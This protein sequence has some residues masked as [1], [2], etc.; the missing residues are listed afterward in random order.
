MNKLSKQILNYF[1]AFTETRFNFRRLISY[2]WTN[3]ELTMS[4]DIYD[5]FYK[6][7]FNG[8]KMGALQ[9]FT[10]KKGEYSVFISKNDFLSRIIEV[11]EKDYNEKYLSSC[12]KTEAEEIARV[13]N[14]FIASSQGLRIAL[15]GDISEEALEQRQDACIK[16]AIRKYNLSLRAKIEVILL[17]LREKKQKEIKQDRNIEYLPSTIININNITQRHFDDL[18]NL[19]SK[20]PDP[21]KYI[22]SVKNYFKKISSDLILYDLFYN[23]QKFHQYQS[24]GTAY[25][26]F[27]ELYES[28]ENSCSFPLY[29]IE[30]NI[31]ATSTEIKITFP[32]N[33]VL[34]NTPAIN[35]FEYENVL[36]VT[37]ATA[38]SNAAQNLASIEVFLQAQYNHTESF[39]LEPRFRPIIP[40]ESKYPEIKSRI[41]VQIISNEN[42]RLL[43]YSEIITDT[44]LGKESTFS[45]FVKK[46]IEGKIESTQDVIDKKFKDNYPINSA[47]RYISDNPLPLNNSQKRILLALQNDKNKVIV[48]DGPPGTGKSHT[49]AAISYWA[50]QNNKSLVITS[51]KKEALDVVERMLE[52]KFKDLHPRSKPPLIRMDSN[53]E[54]INRLENTLQ[55]SVVNAAGDRTHDF[56]ESAISADEKT[57]TLGFEQSIKEQ[58]KLTVDYESNIKKLFEFEK[59]TEQISLQS[60]LDVALFTLPK[61]VKEKKIQFELINNIVRSSLSD[62]LKSVSIE[63]LAFL[64]KNKDAIPSFLEACEKLHSSDVEIKEVS[65]DFDEISE[66]FQIALKTALEYL[67]IQKPF[68]SLSE[69]DLTGGIIKRLIKRSPSKEKLRKS[70]TELKNLKNKR[71]IKEIVRLLEK[72]AENISLQDIE[73]GLQIINSSLA[74]RPYK[75]LIDSYKLFPGREE[76]NLS[77][78]YG[79]ILKLNID[80]LLTQD[81]EISLKRLF[82]HYSVILGELNITKDDLSSIS[83]IA[84]TEENKKLWLWIN[85]HYDLSMATSSTSL[86]KEQIDEYYRLKQKLIEHQND[87]RLKNLNNFQNDMAQIKEIYSNGKRFSIEQSKILFENMPCIIASPEMIS[88]HF[89]MEEQMIDLL[90]FDE[91]SQVSIAESISLILR[92][93]QIVVFGDE[94]QYGAVG[95]INVSK[96]YAGGYFQEII[97]AYGE[98]FNKSISEK[99]RK[100]LIGEVTKEVKEEDVISEKIINPKDIVGS[101]LWLKTFNIRTTTL[102]FAKAIANYSSSLREHFRSFPEII[103][104]SNEFFYKPAQLEL[105]VN[106]IRTKPIGEVLKFMETEAKG[107]SGSNVNYDEIDVIIKDINDRIAAGFKGSIGIITSFREQQVKI[108]KEIAE[109][110][111]LPE[112]KNNHKLAIWF[113]GDVQGEERDIIYYSFV[114]SDK[115][116]NADLRT[117]YPVL[118]GAADDIRNLKMQRLNVGFSRAKDVMVFVHSM[119]IEKYS[120]TRLGDAL[121]HYSSVLEKNK[122]RDIFIEDESVFDSPPEKELYALLKQTPFVQNNLQNIKIIPQFKVGDYIREEFKRYIP[123][124]RADLLLTYSKGGKEQSLIIEYDGVEFHFNNPDIVTRYNYSQ[125]YLEY[126]KSRQLELES[127]GYKFL[128]INKFNLRPEKEGETKINVLNK[129][130]SSKFNI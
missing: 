96:K 84:S 70:I 39:I 79:H 130:V 83:N 44:E 55:I 118:H 127:Y 53:S 8:L 103:G 73:S 16:E 77:D 121:K 113:V 126:D 114:Q 13:N 27:H 116:N 47:K 15:E 60:N 28:N 81:I 75:N 109:R 43:D 101:I 36:A 20:D 7:L 63:E 78:L 115:F 71:I 4:L 26:F 41:G 105:I 22:K 24:V 46:Y 117:I 89:P 54:S 97:N 120:N 37:R 123:K 56:N 29:F 94:Y 82:E 33:L 18:Q 112:L 32:Y 108:E 67:N 34:L 1:A 107:N 21:G 9:D 68:L 93:K 74:L 80:K 124:F 58:L 19:F 50:N 38:I 65:D 98:D 92:A 100:E 42:K 102:S 91:A 62:K 119:P 85:L 6:K 72:S 66:T 69:T 88:K 51:H 106:R 129:L 125:E 61:I 2:Q 104:Y 35:Y 40:R 90:V 76:M 64:I 49:I 12:I 95:A 14:I 111:N 23:L 31:Q 122:G 86:S 57:I 11:I 5:D 52:A 48:V 30:V 3:N 25:V 17:E 110:L 99:E 10:I 87:M 59:L 45:D 128:R